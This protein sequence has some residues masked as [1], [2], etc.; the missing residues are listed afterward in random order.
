MRYSSF[1]VVAFAASAA[2]GGGGHQDG[3][4]DDNQ[5]DHQDDNQKNIFKNANDR[6]YAIPFLVQGV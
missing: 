5:D 3:H 4:Q 6:W 1:L 2:L